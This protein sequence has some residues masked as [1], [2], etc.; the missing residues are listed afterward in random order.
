MANPLSNELEL[1]NK[2]ENIVKKGNSDVLEL[3]DSIWEL[4]D[5]HMGNEV[6]AIQMNV[7]TYIS[8]SEPEVISVESGKRILQNCDRIRNF[9]EKLKK[10]T[11]PKG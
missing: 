9:F 2:I 5:H 3:I 4:T 1:Y 7:G 10:S 11:K 6:Y 8:G